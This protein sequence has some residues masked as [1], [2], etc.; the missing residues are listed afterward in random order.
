[1]T[2][3]LKNPTVLQDANPA[4]FFDQ[5]R[6]LDTTDPGYEGYIMLV[7]LE[8]NNVVVPAIDWIAK[9]GIKIGVHELVNMALDGVL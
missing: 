8:T 5:F 2:K 7:Y 3:D 6:M 4:I 9:P 1:M